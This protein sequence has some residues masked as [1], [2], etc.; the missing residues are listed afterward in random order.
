MPQDICTKC[1]NNKIAHEG[2]P[3]PCNCD[4]CKMIGQ[5]LQNKRDARRDL[6]LAEDRSNN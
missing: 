4:D 6:K 2:L 1:R 5:H 3:L